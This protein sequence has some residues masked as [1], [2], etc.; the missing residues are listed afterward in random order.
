MYTGKATLPP[1][2]AS[3]WGKWLA[4]RYPLPWDPSGKGGGR[5]RRG[6]AAHL[7]LKPVVGLTKSNLWCITRQ[8]QSCET[9]SVR[10][11]RKGQQ[12]AKGYGSTPEP[13]PRWPTARDWRGC[14]SAAWNGRRS[15][16]CRCWRLPPWRWR[17]PMHCR[18]G[19][20]RLQCCAHSQHHSDR[21]LDMLAVRSERIMGK[22]ARLH[23]LTCRGGFRIGLSLVKHVCISVV[24]MLAHCKVDGSALPR[25]DRMVEGLTDRSN[26]LG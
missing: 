6:S 2:L 24:H 1:I 3:I 4:E 19:R 13:A 5:K 15:A 8:K 14:A 25:F 9:R 22:A 26:L 20:C 10:S 7:S 16:A 17:H 11:M 21:S 23:L 12:K 18:P